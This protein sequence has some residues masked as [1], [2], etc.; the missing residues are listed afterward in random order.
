MLSKVTP[1]GHEY[2]TTITHN[3]SLNTAICYIGGFEIRLEML[4]IQ[5]DNVNEASALASIDTWLKEKEEFVD[6][7]FLKNI[8][9]HILALRKALLEQKKQGHAI[10]FM[11][12]NQMYPDHLIPDAQDPRA[13]EPNL[14]STIAQEY[15][16]LA[17]EVMTETQVLDTINRVLMNY[18]AA[19]SEELF[20]PRGDELSAL[21]SQKRTELK[22]WLQNPNDCPVTVKSVL[23]QRS[24]RL[25]LKDFAQVTDD[26]L[27]FLAA[28]SLYVEWQVPYSQVVEVF[29]EV[30]SKLASYR[31]RAVRLNPKLKEAATGWKR[32]GR[33]GKNTM[34]SLGKG[35]Y[36]A[37]GV[38]SSYADAWLRMDAGVEVDEIKNTSFHEAIHQLQ[39]G[40]RESKQI[41]DEKKPGSYTEILTDWV[42]NREFPTSRE[43]GYVIGRKALQTFLDQEMSAGTLTAGDIEVVIDC[44]IAADN[45]KLKT[46]IKQ[47][48]GQNL[49]EVLKGYSD[50]DYY[51]QIGINMSG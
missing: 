50:Y 26:E 21:V 43:S 10:D 3:K 27:V 38:A 19:Q 20:V 49:D 30:D 15:A 23:E 39:M 8:K 33:V 25:F 48:T 42:T 14:T 45:K 31:E 37:H 16:I 12:R 51:K 22:H 28:R 1:L 7:D 17:V 11:Y 13:Q 24:K 6:P 47:K 35:Y 34:A 18:P 44:A 2:F 29:G 32:I 5:G 46:F 41:T 9:P 40:V 36:K 4:G